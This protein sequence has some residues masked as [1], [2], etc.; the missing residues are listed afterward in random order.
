MVRREDK[1][2]QNKL[3]IGS[4]KA[5]PNEAKKQDIKDVNGGY[6]RPKVLDF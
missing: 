1:R 5:R 4:G 6:L 3:L 2:A